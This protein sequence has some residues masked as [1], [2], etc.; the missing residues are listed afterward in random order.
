MTMHIT[1]LVSIQFHFRILYTRNTCIAEPRTEEANDQKKEEREISQ[2]GKEHIREK[3]NS[4][5]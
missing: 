4:Q 3:I 2:Q 1:G 5:N